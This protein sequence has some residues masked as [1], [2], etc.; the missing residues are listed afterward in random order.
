MDEM[1][2]VWGFIGLGRQTAGKEPSIPRSMYKL[3]D[4]ISAQE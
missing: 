4:C 3:P 1:R 2:G